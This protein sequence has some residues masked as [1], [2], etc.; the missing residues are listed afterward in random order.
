MTAA[1]EIPLLRLAAQRLAGGFLPTATDAVRWMT[2]SQGQDLRG[3]MTSV[4]LRTGGGSS[5]DVR[6]AFDRGEIVRSWPMRGTLH[7]VAAEDLP[8]MLH[9][10]A[11]RV[12][13]GAAARWRALELD[14]ATV[15][16]A[17]DVAVTALAGGGRTTRE[18]LFARWQD[19]GIATAGQRG[20]HLILQL[21][22]TQALCYGPFD[23]AKQQLVLMEDWIPRPRALD[24]DEALGEWA[25]RFFASHGPATVADFARWTKLPLGECRKGIAVAQSGL[26]RWD[27]EGVTHWMDP[28]TPA[29]LAA[30]RSRARGVFLLP[31]FDE[32]VLG[33]ADRSVIIPVEHAA[34]VVPGNNGVFQHT[35]VACGQVV[36]TWKRAPRGSKQPLIATPLASFSP[37]VEREIARLAGALP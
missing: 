16:S 2:A 8:W 4:A 37:T 9:V 29:R 20:V 3:A 32:Y 23:G 25:L 17:H 19:A 13:S 28:A 18:E 11:G 33:Y 26:E 35:V 6:A 21:A 7:I 30:H 27:V 34:A 5:A 15:K 14:D 10:A 36:G 31:G 24:H 12:M 22:L 1:A